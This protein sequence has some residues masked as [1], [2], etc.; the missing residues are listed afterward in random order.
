M[1]REANN[2]IDLLLRRVSGRDGEAA[3]GA[4][5]DERHLDADELSSYAQ[6]ALP[7][8]ARA[9]Y[10]EHIADCVACRKLV[11]E[12]SLSLGAVAV[13]A[14]V[15][16]LP[17]PG[18]LKKFLA[19][20]FSPL[21]LRYAVPA[22]GV[23]V[24]MIVGFV[25][26]RQQRS[27][28]MVATLN[29]QAKESVRVTASPS[30]A[31]GFQ[32]AEPRTPDQP[33]SVAPKPVEPKAKPGSA[34]G[35]A[36]GAG[37]A[38]PVTVANDDRAAAEVR[39][40]AAATPPA[41]PAKA[42]AAEP[43]TQSAEAGKKQPAE[44]RAK[45]DAEAVKQEA[46]EYKPRD[47]ISL[48]PQTAT[49]RKAQDKSKDAPSDSNTRGFIGGL[50]G[51]RPGSATRRTPEAK[52]EEEKRGADEKRGDADQVNEQTRTIAGR[53]FRKARGIW[54]DTAYDSSTAT[55]NMA[56]NSEQFRALVAD[57]PAIGTI[58]KQLDG[59]VIV[60]WKGRAYHIR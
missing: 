43:E 37:S 49:T 50:A 41:A 55:V 9:R 52:R 31:G 30:P 19:S 12:L 17:A 1:N 26:L 45:L 2:D 28:P 4:P 21:V 13:A 20:L 22:L 57:E 32:D 42:A 58:A 15:E 6:N 3:S 29:D 59:E 39:P 40:P 36:A 23:I 47:Q 27:H 14:P 10:T 56:R 51:A 11:T 48:T 44:V 34:S 53:H 7:P 35:G 24:V 38:A 8:T 16:T 25:V 46:D 54:T 5:A 33:Q 60:V 18:G